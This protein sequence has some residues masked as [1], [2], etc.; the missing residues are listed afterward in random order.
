LVGP[1][2][3]LLPALL[4]LAASAVLARADEPS[5]SAQIDAN[6]IGVSDQ[7]QLTITVQGR[8][9][10]LAEPVAVPPL[11]NLRHVG[12]PFQSSQV[13]FVNGAVSQTVSF[14]FVLQPVAVGPAEVGAAQ[15]KLAGGVKTTAPMAVEVVAGSI[16]PRRQAARDP[17][18]DA[19]GADPFE[20]F[21]R[22]RARPEP[23][24]VVSAVASRNRAHVGE[25]ILVTYFLYTQASVSNVQLTSAPQ[26]PGFWAEDPD[27]GKATNPQGER[28]TL[29]GE[30]YVRFPILRKLLFP[31]RAGSLK[32]PPATFRVVMSRMAFFDAGPTTVDRSTQPLTLTAD[33]VPGGPDSSGAVGDF[34]VTATL[35]RPAVGLGEA[36]TLRFT[37]AG[38]GN[39]KWVERGPELD[40]TG[41]RVYPPQ[42]KSDLK[43]SLSGIQGSKT[44]EYVVVPETSGALTIPA[45]PFSYFSPAA[46][47]EKHLRS[48]PLTLQVHGGTAAAAGADAA[49]P[50]PAPRAGGLALRSDLDPPARALASLGPRPLLMA[51]GLALA[52]HA[53]IASGSLWSARRAAAGG[54]SAPRHTVRRA[55]GE[56]EQARRG[57]VSKEQ[58]AAMIERTLHGVFGPIEENGAA[59]AGERERA[60]REVLQQVQFIRYAPQLGDYSEKISAVAG[61]A[62]EVVRRWA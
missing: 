33:P 22:G 37:V 31:T 62:A 10:E 15:V 29:E 52:L 53:A 45:L 20:T 61:R 3:R 4:C 48:A 24:L 25:P 6:R 58:A 42:V 28:T 12:G 39:L 47:A 18:G 27:Q 35:D 16:R 46:G 23:K 40:L 30:S 59:P 51:L 26:Y 11:K 1:A 57:G 13:S 38:S 34:Q 8:S 55:L 21:R 9:A 2:R 5:V 50:R 32:I 49:P 60:I 14:T 44:W 36:A 19:F 54:R 17:F 56:L 41:A 7:V 43:V